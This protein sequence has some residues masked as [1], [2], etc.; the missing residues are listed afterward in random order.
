VVSVLE[1]LLAMFMKSVT[2]LI[3][4]NWMGYPFKKSAKRCKPDLH[5]I[6]VLRTGPWFDV[7]KFVSKLEYVTEAR[8]HGKSFI[9]QVQTR[10]LPLNIFLKTTSPF[11]GKILNY[12]LQ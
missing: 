9:Y 4:L 6:L 8:K 12:A 1:W 3:N 7:G 11:P 10:S 5:H 2:D